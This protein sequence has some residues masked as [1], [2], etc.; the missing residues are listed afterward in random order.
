MA[1]RRQHL[2]KQ[3]ENNVTDM[4]K[5]SA[6]FHNIMPYKFCA[7]TYADMIFLLYSFAIAN[8]G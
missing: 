7:G 6:C 2:D 3:S 5:L 8:S 1:H 4:I